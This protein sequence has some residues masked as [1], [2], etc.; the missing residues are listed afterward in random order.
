MRPR[1]RNWSI[2]PLTGTVLPSDLHLPTE[3]PSNV[4]PTLKHCGPPTRGG[5]SAAVQVTTTV[6]SRLTT[7]SVLPSFNSASSCLRKTQNGSS[8]W[9]GVGL[10][11]P[12]PRG[13]GDDAPGADLSPPL[14]ADTNNHRPRNAAGPRRDLVNLWEPATYKPTTTSRQRTSACRNRDLGSLTRPESHFGARSGSGGACAAT[15]F[16]AATR[17]VQSPIRTRSPPPVGRQPPSRRRA[18]A[19]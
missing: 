5:T 3:K 15:A 13:D 8:A 16:R 6:R 4:S 9:P 2:T 10:A 11:A 17:E 7:K 18:G 12:I 14:H 1:W 19:G